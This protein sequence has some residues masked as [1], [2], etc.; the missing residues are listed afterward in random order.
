MSVGVP[1]AHGDEVG[2]GHGW[3]H[4]IA[5]RPVAL[6]LIFGSPRGLLHGAQLFGTGGGNEARVGLKGA[7]GGCITDGAVGK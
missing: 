7:A 2:G 5:F 4:V 3:G 1:A 6:L